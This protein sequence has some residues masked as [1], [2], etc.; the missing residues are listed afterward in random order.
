MDKVAW[1]AGGA[2]FCR[3]YGT[4]RMCPI[5]YPALKCWAIFLAS[6]TGRM[7]AGA[8]LRDRVAAGAHLR[9]A[10][11]QAPFYGRHCRGRTPAGRI[12]AGAHQR[13]TWP[14]G[15]PPAGGVCLRRTPAG[16]IALGAYLRGG[17]LP[18]APISAEWGFPGG[19]IVILRGWTPFGVPAS[20]GGAFGATASARSRGSFGRPVRSGNA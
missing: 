20:A 15:A 13:G 8:H 14:A 18:Q 10:L 5:F 1:M 17:A 9:D 2:G 12:A 6:P 7:A 3:A 4:G 16:G 11:P 19:R